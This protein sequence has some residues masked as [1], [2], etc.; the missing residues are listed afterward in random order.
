MLQVV[1]AYDRS[2]ITQLATD[3]GDALQ[4]K[5][6]LAARTFRDRDHWLAPFERIEILSRLAFLMDAE[7][8]RLSRLIPQE[9]GKP[10]V[11][12]VGKRG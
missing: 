5:I 9:G 4:A 1:Q 11:V 10:L 12:H 2:P 6:N 3:D 8:D 7:R